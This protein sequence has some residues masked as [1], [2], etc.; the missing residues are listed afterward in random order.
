MAFKRYIKLIVCTET[1]RSESTIKAPHVTPAMIDAAYDLI[2]TLGCGKRRTT[3]RYTEELA[4]EAKLATKKLKKPTKHKK[5]MLAAVGQMGADAIAKELGRPSRASRIA[6][7]LRGNDD[8][9]GIHAMV[10]GNRDDD[11]T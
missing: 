9:T 10:E 4:R 6:K 7:P 3:R 8:G 2:Y 1:G 5:A 11:R